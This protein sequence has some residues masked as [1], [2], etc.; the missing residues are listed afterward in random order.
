MASNELSVMLTAK[1]NLESELKKNR[2]RLKELNAEIRTIQS[3]GGTVGDDLAAEF[4]AAS[5]A[6]QKL[7]DEVNTTNKKIKQMAT[8]SGGAAS[9]FS[10]AWQKAASAFNNNFVAGL[11]TASLVYFGKQAVQTFA[12]VE[13]AQ[14][15]LTATFGTQGEALIKWANASADAFNLSQAQALNAVQTFA[16]FGESAGLAGQDLVTFS[17]SL[18]ERAADLASYF[19]G[20]TEDAIT[21]IGSALRGEAEPARRYG[22]LLDDLSLKAEYLALTGEKV[23]GTLLPQQKILAAQSLIMRQSARAQGDVSRTANSMANKL[24]DAQQKMD[25][26]KA[27]AGQTI[28]VALSPLLNILN[29]AMAMF[30]SLPAPLKSAAIAIGMIAIAALIATPRIIAFKAN[31]AMAG[32]SA[33]RFNAM[34]LKTAKGTLALVAAFA[35]MQT[36]GKTF[37]S[38]DYDEQFKSL[39]GLDKALHVVAKPTRWD[40]VTAGIDAVASVFGFQSAAASATKRLVGFDEKL[41]NLVDSGKTNQAR[42]LYQTLVDGAAS[43]GGT[44]ADVENALPGYVSK[45]KEVGRATGEVAKETRSAEAALDNLMGAMSRFAGA[46]DQTKALLDFKDAVKESV[47]KPSEDAATAVADAFLS[48]FDTYEKGSRAQADFVRNNYDA[49]AKAIKT[50]GLSESM[51]KQ[52]LGPLNDAKKEAEALV[53]ILQTAPYKF[54]IPRPDQRQYATGGYVSGPGTGTS[55]SIPALLSN[56]EYVIRA[57][58]VQRLGIGTLDK[59]NRA[60]KMTDPALVGKQVPTLQPVAVPAG[61]PLIGSIVVNNPQAEID[62]EKAVTR[63]LMRAE[64]IRKERG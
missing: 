21:A 2:D 59:I 24:K 5:V 12:Q 31:L 38:N 58:A 9:K 18:A 4:R 20:S 47:S 41:T 29:G 60:D 28:S 45:M 10:R 33:A 57:A 62:V 22:I 37:G 27:T 3:T 48:A 7:S 63:G 25:D 34:A 17:S 14:S 26:F 53:G 55:D 42:K 8:D 13:D 35:A 51:Q 32:I 44:V 15:A 23:T 46:V 49:V 1:G 16:I 19:G 43:W 56:G 64:R 6:A 40:K 36:V 39:D 52:L 11:S 61:G 50:S 54:G 30:A